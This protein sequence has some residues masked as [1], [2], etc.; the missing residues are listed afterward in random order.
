[1][2]SLSYMRDW[3]R[4]YTAVCGSLD[5]DKKRAISAALCRRVLL[6]LLDTSYHSGRN[7]KGRLEIKI[8][9]KRYISAQSG[10]L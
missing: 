5:T 4:V 2:R 8:K 7:Y 10:I 3:I 1:M 6:Y 9:I